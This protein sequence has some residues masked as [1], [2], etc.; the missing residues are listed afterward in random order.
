MSEQAIE[1]NRL[2]LDGRDQVEALERDVDLMREKAT[3]ALEVPVTVDGQTYAEVTF[4]FV[5]TP[6]PV[7]EKAIKGWRKLHPDEDNLDMFKSE[8]FQ[9]MLLSR[10][11]NLPMAVIAALDV[12]DRIACQQKVFV[13]LGKRLAM[14]LIRVA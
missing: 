14:K 6:S 13:W 2:A 4:D 1:T 11:A 3:F 10:V 8:E 9:Q 7:F 12:W 5:G